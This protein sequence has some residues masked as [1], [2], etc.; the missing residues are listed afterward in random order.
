VD[1]GAIPVD[2]L[3]RPCSQHVEDLQRCKHQMQW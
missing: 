1:D 2:E 3:W